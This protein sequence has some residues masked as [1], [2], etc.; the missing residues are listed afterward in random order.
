MGL[1][2]TIDSIDELCDLMCNNVT[3]EKKYSTCK[4]CGRKLKN[5]QA[6]QLGMGAICYRK[7]MSANKYKPLFS[8][9]VND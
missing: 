1:E 5:E 8:R 6:K 9:G 3:P 7:Y 4:R 2:I